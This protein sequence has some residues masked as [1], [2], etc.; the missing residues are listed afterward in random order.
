MSL[1]KYCVLA[2]VSS[3]ATPVAGQQ[4]TPAEIFERLRSSIVKIGRSAANT[5]T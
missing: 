4:L 1:L 3:L 5:E 2:V